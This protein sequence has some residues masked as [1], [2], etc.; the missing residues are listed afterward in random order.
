MKLKR[1]FLGAVFALILMPIN[2]TFADAQDF[3]FED[4][5]ADYYLT[6]LEDGTSNL[7]VKE[8]LTAVFP[9]MN[10]NHGITRTIP[11]T[12]QGGA[13]RTVANET[14]LNLTVLRNGKPENINKIVENDG[15]FTVYI[16]SASEYVYGEQVYT[17]EYDYTDVITE[18]D[19]HGM[20]VSG[21]DGV[22]KAFQELYWDTNGTGWKQEFGKLTARLH[23]PEEVHENMFDEVWCYVGSY[24]EKGE[25]RCMITPTED[26]YSFETEDLAAGENLTFV[27][28][29][30]PDTFKVVLEKSYILVILLVGEI[31]LVVI[32]L[33]R[34][35][36]KWRKT[37][38][39]QYDLYKSLFDTPQYQPPEG[40]IHVAD[41]EQIYL[42]KTESSYVATLLELAVSKAVTIKKIENEKE[43][44][45]VVILNIEPG[46]LS[47][48]QKEMMNIIAGNGG[49]AKG[50]E[51]PIQ[52][53]KASRYLAMC[54]ED[55]KKDAIRKLERHGYLVKDENKTRSGLTIV[56]LVW[57]FVL[58]CFFITAGL[59]FIVNNLGDL[60]IPSQNAII[61]GGKNVLLVMLIIFIVFCVSSWILKRQTNKYKRYTEKGIKLVKYLEGLELYINMAEA[62]RL[63][64]LQSVEGADTS[65]EGIVKL[66]EK[67]LPWASLFGAEESW[68]KELEKYYEIE[69][70]NEAVDSDILR[71]MMLSDISH[72]ISRVIVSSTNYHEPISISSSGGSGGSWSSSSSGG[73]GG[74]SSSGGGF[75]GGGGGGGGGGGW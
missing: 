38:K 33:T 4:F 47:S 52:K 42:K 20:N 68:M 50:D 57:A 71:G 69:N 19:K 54:A 67:L 61:V 59:P 73:G 14:A 48:S 55:Y 63:K 5:T 46:E 17:L 45:W 2:N 30:K 39:P 70:I 27:T 10:Q 24:G 43:Y 44:N 18:F 35:Y 7:H 6:K 72:D 49:L 16:G 37:A 22:E 25:D 51:Y 65:N 9:E 26:G 11:Y 75:S 56:G 29:F 41:G 8:V 62:D 36:L 13:N 40:N 31:V 66:Y 34:K 53:H 1:L 32:L 3:Y 21:M 12:N 60:L 23:V 28:E 64:F 74:S 15:Y 58:F